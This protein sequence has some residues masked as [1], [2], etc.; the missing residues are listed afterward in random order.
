MPPSRRDD[1]IDAAMRV[2]YR[3][4]FHASGLDKILKEGGI[5]RMTLYNHFKS[6]DEL[7]VAALRRR[8][9]TFR[10]ELIEFVEGKSDDPIERL[11]AVFE[12]VER[13]CA[14]SE[15]AGC[16]FVNVAAEYPDPASPIREVAAE[17]KLKVLRYLRGLCRQGGVSDPDELSSQLAILLDG[18]AVNSYVVC[19]GNSSIPPTHPVALARSAAHVLIER[20]LDAPGQPQESV[21]KDR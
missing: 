2:F 13:W 4:G 3:S 8:D 19:Q 17:H 20:A 5:S 21:N 9:E 1:L 10:E 16:M 14:S 6:K 12:F 7:I 15:F 11:D 18:A